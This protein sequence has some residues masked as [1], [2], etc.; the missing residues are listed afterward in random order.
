M[1]PIAISKEHECALSEVAERDG[2]VALQEGVGHDAAGLA[3]R[4]LG[5]AGLVVL[6][7]AGGDGDPLA[8]VALLIVLFGRG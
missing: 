7:V 2:H 6:G 5:P 3:L 4:P 1:L 8:E